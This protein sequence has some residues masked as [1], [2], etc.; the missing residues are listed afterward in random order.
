MQDLEDD[1]AAYS[2][3]NIRSMELGQTIVMSPTLPPTGM[4]AEADE[5]E[6]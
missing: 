4:N 5:S 1:E 2:R 3:R 6:S